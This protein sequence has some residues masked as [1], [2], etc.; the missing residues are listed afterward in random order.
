SRLVPSPARSQGKDEGHISVKTT[1]IGAYPKISDASD[2][3]ELRR[4]LH[5]FD[6]DEIDHAALEVVFA[7]T[8]KRAVSEMEKAGIDVINDGQIR[9]DDLLAPFARAWKGVSRGP[10]ERFYDNNTYFRQP[11]IE[12][13]IATDGQTLVAEFASARSAAGRDLKAAICG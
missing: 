6:R 3:Q 5:R 10:L 7:A 13:A 9:W 1:V 2:G 12:G 4:A 11:V 8:T